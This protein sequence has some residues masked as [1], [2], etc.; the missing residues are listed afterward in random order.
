MEAD[1]FEVVAFRPGPSGYMSYG[2]HVC[3]PDMFGLPRRGRRVASFRFRWDAR[4]YIETALQGGPQVE[5]MLRKRGL[6]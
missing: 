2:V 3:E 5:R 4:K 1:M 6:G